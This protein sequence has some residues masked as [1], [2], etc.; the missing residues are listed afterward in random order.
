MLGTAT[1]RRVP[2]FSENPA[3]FDDERSDLGQRPWQ[4][5]SHCRYS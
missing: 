2:G 4:S 1:R 3:M 5:L